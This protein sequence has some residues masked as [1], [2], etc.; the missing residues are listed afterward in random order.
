MSADTGQPVVRNR[1][2]PSCG[3]Y[4]DPEM[5]GACY[6]PQTKTYEQIADEQTRR[7]IALGRELGL[8]Y[9]EINGV[10]YGPRDE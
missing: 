10:R 8:P 3:G 6:S 9:V 7:A 2:C 4:H 1:Y 5:T